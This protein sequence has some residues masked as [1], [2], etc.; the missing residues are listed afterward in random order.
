MA[1]V[2]KNYWFW[3]RSLSATIFDFADAPENVLKRIG[4]NISIPEDLMNDLDHWFNVFRSNEILIRAELS[5]LITDILTISKKY[6]GIEDEFW[7][8]QG[9]CDHPDW[10][11][12]RNKCRKYIIENYSS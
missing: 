4:G 6:D 5:N 2:D 3:L 12:I 10:A 8:N 11:V 7:T 1:D 9:F